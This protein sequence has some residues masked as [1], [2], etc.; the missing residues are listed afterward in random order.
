VQWSGPGPDSLNPDHI[1]RPPD[2]GP[3]GLGTHAGPGTV[4]L[5]MTGTDR[6]AASCT[7]APPDTTTPGRRPTAPCFPA[8]DSAPMSPY[9]QVGR[10]APVTSPAAGGC[11]IRG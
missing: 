9:G 3:A 8:I 2:A 5:R 11:G 10:P 1:R 7:A 4:D 6:S